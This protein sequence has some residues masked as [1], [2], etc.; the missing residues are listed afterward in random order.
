MGD[1]GFDIENSQK[2]LAGPKIPIRINP[3]IGGLRFVYNFILGES[4]LL[5]CLLTF[6]YFITRRFNGGYSST[7]KFH[8][9]ISKILRT[10]P[11]FKYLRRDHKLLIL[12][13]LKSHPRLA[14]LIRFI[15]IIWRYRIYKLYY[16][17]AL[18]NLSYTPVLA[19]QM[20]LLSALLINLWVP[21]VTLILFLTLSGLLNNLGGFI[22]FYVT[23]VLSFLSNFLKELRDIIRG[24]K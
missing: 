19:T 15:D 6:Y 12:E 17:L 10:N 3:Y 13:S 11:F 1:I 18:L 5:T 23:G 20:G 7:E 16:V 4:I 14:Y 22:L 24:K 21:L 8:R 9:S 2:G